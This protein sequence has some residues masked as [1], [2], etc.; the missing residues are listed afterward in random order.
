MFPA[1]CSLLRSLGFDMMM[2]FL[3]RPNKPAIRPFASRTL[4]LGRT[5]MSRIST[6]L[7]SMAAAI[8]GRAARRTIRGSSP[9]ST[10]SSSG[11]GAPK[12]EPS[13]SSQ[14]GFSAGGSSCTHSPPC[15]PVHA[16]PV[17]RTLEPT[18][19]AIFTT[20]PV[21]GSEPG[22]LKSVSC[23]TRYSHGTGPGGDGFT[24][25]APAESGGT[26]PASSSASSA[27]SS[28]VRT[29]SSARAS[30]S[31]S[32]SRRA[33]V[34]WASVPSCAGTSTKSSGLA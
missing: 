13:T 7:L 34:A 9:A 19:R 18:F 25:A 8:T 20:L 11:P 29:A 22:F 5:T 26:A 2:P 15:G 28:A 3:S 27:S 10:R 6:L 17:P 14:P 31:G 33:R 24:T 4:V 23:M 21:V 12:L 30:V 16:L 32:S 1:D